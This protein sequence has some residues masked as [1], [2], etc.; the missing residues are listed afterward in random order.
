MFEPES[1]LAEPVAIPAAG[2]GFHTVL[3]ANRGE[4]ACRVI[5]TLR[6]LGIRSVAVY[7]DADR[8]ARH[9]RMA[10][11]ALRIGPAP[12][13]QSYLDGAAII[14]AAMRSGAQAL[15][16]GYGFLAE[17][18]AFARDCAAAGLVFIGPSPHALEQMG[19]KIR[20][21]TLVSA[22]GVP[23]TPGIAEPGLGDDDLIRAAERIGYPVLIKPS[24]GGGGK[25]MEA[26]ANAAEL[27]AAL[28]ASRR[29]AL[30]A[31]G[32]DT[33]FIERLIARPRHIE[34]Q[35]LADAHGAV[36]HFGERECSLQRRHQKVIEEAPSALLSEQTRQRIGA[37]ACEVARSVGYAGAGTVEFLVSDDD[38]DEFFFMEMN[39]RLQVEHPVTE[40]VTGVDL[41]AWQVRIAAGEPLTLRQAEVAITGHAVEARVYAEDPRNG[42]LPQT[43]TVLALHEPVGEGIRVD[44][45]LVPGLVVGAHYD[46]MLAKVVAWAPDR[47]V[48][49]ER[50]ERALHDSV[51]LGVR[52]NLEYLAALVADDDVRAARLD[53]GLIE[54]RLPRMEFRPP[55]ADVLVAAALVLHS[56]GWRSARSP[57]AGAP[58]TEP[59]GWRIDGAPVPTAYTL[60][61]PGRVEIQVIGPP[62]AA[63]VTLHRL[64]GEPADGLESRR[65]GPAALS[66]D[67]DRVSVEFDG[68][69]RT[70]S[71]AR[72]LADGPA[73][74]T[75]PAALWFGADAVAWR[76]VP[77]SRRRLL[78]EHLAA[79]DRGDAAPLPEVR[80]PMPGTVV[81]VAVRDGDQVGA[82]T[83]LLT[84]EAMKMEH[85]LVAPAAGTARLCV[86]PGQTVKGDQIVATVEPST[87]TAD[88]GSI[89]HPP[90]EDTP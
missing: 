22:R 4:I 12:A 35:V 85:R 76:I 50:L 11:V 49:L 41:V 32:D 81:G 28:V 54:R 3:V 67:G 10:D 16:P 77:V 63:T 86:T 31:F 30:A 58:W 45:S 20:A 90:R 69:R 33:L 52:T 24:A 13:T 75:A 8:D 38:P 46:P 84:V 42:F 53:T 88:E 37:A 34:V 78:E 68:E 14:E 39:T 60:D 43:G 55:P 25:G 82:G 7:S 47:A 64:P 17:N 9:V 29:V 40:L 62:D 36:I 89:R 80:S 83:T 48:A 23:V 2:A 51:V 6:E 65:S 19:D 70:V 21:K 44:S 26:V 57:W 15:H 72:E 56:A 87:D 61:A 79:R 18:A 5:R 1:A 66:I 59:T 71:F 73:A 74:D 27:P